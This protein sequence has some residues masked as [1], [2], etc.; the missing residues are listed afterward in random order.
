MTLKLAAFLL[1]SVRIF[2]ATYYISASGS[3][4]NDGMSSSTPW[5]TVAK[6]NSGTYS[7]GDSILFRGGDTFSGTISLTLT[8]S[9][10]LQSSISSYGTGRA[11]ISSG[12]GDGVDLGNSEFVSITNLAFAGSGWM[13]SEPNITV[14]NGGTGI[15]FHVTKT[16]GGGL[17]NVVLANNVISGYWIGIHCDFTGSSSTVGFLGLQ[18]YGN[19]VSNDLSFGIIVQGYDSYLGGPVNQSQG[20]YVGYNTLVNIPGDPQSG[21]GG[22]HGPNKTEAGGIIVTSSTGVTIEHNYMNRI[23]GWGGYYSGLSLGGSSAVTVSNSRDFRINN[24]EITGTACST[25]FDGSAIDLDQDTQSGEIAYN[26]TYANVGP[27]FQVGSFGGKTSGESV[28]FH[29]NISYND[30]RGESS[31]SQQGAVRIW[32]NTNGLAIYNNSIYVSIA[33]TEGQAAAI[34]WEVGSNVN[35]AIMNNILKMTGGLPFYWAATNTNATHLGSP[36]TL[37]N[38][39][40]ASGGA[41]FMSNDNGS[42]YTTIASLGAWQ[43]IGS[44]FENLNSITYGVTADAGFLNLNG[45]SVPSGGF[46][47][48]NIT[49]AYMDLAAGSAA[50]GAG[51]DPWIEAADLGPIDFHGNYARHGAPVDI[52]A[53]SYLTSSSTP[54]LI[55]RGGNILR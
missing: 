38:L 19:V 40:D 16:A 47:Q 32:G 23:A 1:V 43:A 17:R 45:F 4:S 5:Q 28:K 41:F 7:A 44:G 33:G 31:A 8:G 18:I 26:F 2:A 12:T 11:T 55:F 48:S 21:T 39:Y 20:V 42:A 13:G 52:G 6:V 36:I 51:V 49:M 54:A 15:S 35:I 10:A 37:N 29:H 22:V 27:S 9:A 46:L 30:V 24:N 25:Y 34:N 3:D 14:L 50:I 53:A